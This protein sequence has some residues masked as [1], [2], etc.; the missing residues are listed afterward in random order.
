MVEPEAVTGVLAPFAS[1]ELDGWRERLEVHLAGCLPAPIDELDLVAIGMR[2][3]VLSP[4]KRVRPLLLVS[5]TAA[6]GGKVDDVM[7]A[8][9]ALELVHA[10]SLVLDDLPCMDDASLRRGRPTLHL[11]FGED[12]AALVATALVSHAFRLVASGGSLQAGARAEM[13]VVLADAV[14]HRGLVSGQLSDLRGA[15]PQGAARPAAEAAQVNQFKTG[16]LFRAAF[17]M[18]ALATG[19]PASSRSRLERCADEIGQAFQLLDDLK[20]SGWAPSVGKSLHQDDGKRTLLSVLGRDAAERR[21]AQ[22]LS[23]A[24]ALLREEFGAVGPVFRL[25][26]RAMA[27][28]T[29]QSSLTRQNRSST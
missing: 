4:G 5:A 12:V 28:A 2:E 3:A 23:A 27:G 21:L 1:A 29:P 19:A 9:C 14:G 26:S 13:V 20:D 22:H 11:Q 16:S 18:A 10:A 25:L 6:L 15:S 8:A 24:K 7:D 17:S